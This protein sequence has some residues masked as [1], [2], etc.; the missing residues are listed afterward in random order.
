LPLARL[1]LRLLEGRV[2]VCRLDPAEPIPAWVLAGGGFASITRAAGEL[3]VVCAEDAVPA[4][5]TCESGWRIFQVEGPLDFSLT[6]I[7]A[8]VAQ[9]LADAGVS[10]FAVS[11]YDTDHV[12]VKEEDVQRAVRALTAAGHRVTAGPTS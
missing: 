1:H 4:G 7:L 9:P 12:L 3:S 6:G 5:T 8:S 10:I 11:T 2:S